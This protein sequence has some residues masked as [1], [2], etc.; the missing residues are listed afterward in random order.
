[1]REFRA[2][3]QKKVVKCI[4]TSIN[5]YCECSSLKPVP[6]L[7]R[8]KKCYVKNSFTNPPSFSILQV[9][10]TPIWNMKFDSLFFDWTLIIFTVSA[11]QKDER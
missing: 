3:L 10:H 11:V 1:M 2:L 5:Y 6:S 7:K 9:R 4:E 8:R